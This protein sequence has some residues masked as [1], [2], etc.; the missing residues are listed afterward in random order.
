MKKIFSCIIIV[1]MVFMATGCKNRETTSGIRHAGFA[2]SSIEFNCTEFMPADEEDT[3]YTKIW[4][5][6]DSKIITE[7]GVIY[8]V[9]LDSEFSNGQSCMQANF[10]KKVTAILDDKIARAD[11]G[12]LY[13]LVANGNAAAYSVVT[14]DDSSY[15]IYQILFKDP[16]TTKIVTVDSNSG[17][18]YLL[19]RDGN[20]YKY[21]ISKAN[22]S[23]E[24]PKL[25]ESSIVYSKAAY[26]SILDFSY[27]LTNLGTN[28]IRSNTKLFRNIASNSEECS[29]YA[30]IQCHYEMR[31]DTDLYQYMDKVIAYNGSTII[32]SYGSIFSLSY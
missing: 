24:T 16:E 5:Y 31:Q 32:T 13:Y 2:L 9:A 10:T 15:Q 3:N 1:V 28:Y 12:K 21:V 7:Y 26:G 20:V 11:D 18:Y 6:S 27:S 30:D 23:N 19:K 8:E 29:K 14:S 17:I 4:F 22:S 25:I